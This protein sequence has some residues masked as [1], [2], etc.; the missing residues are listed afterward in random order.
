VVSLSEACG[1]LA[2]FSPAVTHSSTNARNPDPKPIAPIHPRSKFYRWLVICACYEAEHPV[3]RAR[4]FRSSLGY[5]A[6]PG[7]TSSLGFLFGE[8]L[9]EQH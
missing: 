5:F 6:S 7:M 9:V 2:N 1:A 3:Q 4:K 8:E